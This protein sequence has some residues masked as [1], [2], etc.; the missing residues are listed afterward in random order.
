MSEG[1]KTVNRQA[2]SKVLQGSPEH[3]RFNVPR[4]EGG[5]EGEGEE[6]TPQ[7]R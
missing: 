4:R 3:S 2:F 5:G 6:K 7:K 1:K